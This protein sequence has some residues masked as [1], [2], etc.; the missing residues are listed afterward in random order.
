MSV[1]DPG[2]TLIA[3]WGAG[4]S[5]LLALVK[6]YELWRDRSRLEVSYNFT[7]SK[8]IGNEVLIRNLSNH[9]LI[10]TYWELLYCSGRWPRR[11][12]ESVETAEHDDSDYRIEPH[13]TLRL[14]FADA[15]HFDWG[16]IALNGRRIYIRLHIAGRRPRLHF[17]YAQ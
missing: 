7:S 2:P 17:V 9:P 15:R 1:A 13:A 14:R 6:F 16:P 8:T 10:L 12:F 11:T 3:W 5:T 4:L